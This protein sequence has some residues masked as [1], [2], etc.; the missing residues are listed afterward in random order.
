MGAFFLWIYKHTA[1]HLATAITFYLG[2]WG[3]LSMSSP[4]FGLARLFVYAACLWTGLVG[5][6]WV[7]RTDEQLPVRVFVA[8]LLGLVVF[9]VLPQTL[10]SFTSRES[11]A[12]QSSTSATQQIEESK[13]QVSPAPVVQDTAIFMEAQWLSL[14]LTV[15]HGKSLNVIPLNKKR[16]EANNWGFLDV[17]GLAEDGKWPRKSALEKSKEPKDPGVFVYRIRIANRGP[18]TIIYLR[19]PIDIWFGNKGGEENKQRYTAILSGLG[20]KDVL[21]FY[22]VNDCHIGVTAIWQEIATVQILGEASQRNVP[23]RRAFSNPIEQIMTFLPT[24]VRWIGG[25]PCE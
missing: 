25:E 24:S 8:L 23:L 17:S 14:P 2:G 21:E 7:F 9:F 15:E 22:L 12:T 5:A 18:Q 6:V 1:W 10:R 20:P 3:L 19:V 16:I 13:S 4:P 11:S